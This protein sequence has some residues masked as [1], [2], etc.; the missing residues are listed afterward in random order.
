[1][2]SQGVSEW[3]VEAYLES[4]D[5]LSNLQLLPY[6]D[7]IEK[8]DLPVEG[9]LRGRSPTF[10][11]EHSIP[12]DKELY[13]ANRLLDF[14]K[15]RDGLLRKRYAEILGFSDYSAPDEIPSETSKLSEPFEAEISEK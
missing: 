7:N 3:A 8:S 9:W 11:L 4:K 2:L 15:A 1:L 12:D 14:L 5:R 13:Q 6:L 10:G